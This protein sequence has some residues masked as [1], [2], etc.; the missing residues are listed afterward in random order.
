MVPIALETVL[1]GGL[2]RGATRVAVPN[3]YPHLPQVDFVDMC[4]IYPADEPTGG[5]AEGQEFCPK[6]VAHSLET[7]QMGLGETRYE[8]Y[9]NLLKAL[10][11]LV[12]QWRRDPRVTINR[13]APKHIRQKYVQAHRISADMQ[14]RAIQAAKEAWKWLA[15][16]IDEAGESGARWVASSD[17]GVVAPQEL[18]DDTGDFEYDFLQVSSLDEAEA[19]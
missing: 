8:A 11:L 9:V 18:L 12:D 7:D 3:P 2:S 16:W 6:F 4:V 17:S 14:T 19:A 13:H 5:Y 15:G 1:D 10:I